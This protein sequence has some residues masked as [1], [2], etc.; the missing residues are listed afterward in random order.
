MKLN[1]KNIFIKNLKIYNLYQY[2]IHKETS[3]TI[4]SFRPVHLIFF[5]CVV[6]FFC[7]D[8]S[9][10]LDYSLALHIL[11][12]KKKKTTIHP[13]YVC[14]HQ[15][16]GDIYT[17]EADATLL[18]TGQEVNL[19]VVQIKSGVTQQG[20]SFSNDKQMY[21]VIILIAQIQKP[22]PTISSLETVPRYNN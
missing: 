21:Q 13:G 9:V 6:F 5:S 17:T 7:G 18:F 22:S 2:S 4:T 19:C 10:V 1:V 8:G 11:L 3:V 20:K 16:F 12:K 15:P 14:T